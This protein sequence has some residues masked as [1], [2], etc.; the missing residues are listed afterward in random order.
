MR[1]RA[2]LFAALMLSPI[3]ASAAPSATTWTGIWFGTGQPDNKAEMY[4]DYFLP[5]GVFR[6]HELLA[7]GV[8]AVAHIGATL[9]WRVS[10]S[11]RE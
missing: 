11:K 10:N 5:N 7:E 3:A 2:L 6:N 9:G 1:L 4:I 8:H